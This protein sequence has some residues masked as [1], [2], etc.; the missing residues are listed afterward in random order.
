M[1]AGMLVKQPSVDHV[2]LADIDQPRAQEVAENLALEATA[3]DEVFDRVDAVVIAAATSAHAE[4]IGR[5]ATAGL[6]AFCEKPIA[7]DVVSTNDVI[8]VVDDAGTVLQVGF[9]R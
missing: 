4:L 1:H 3:I 7:V 5:A 6:P 8:R 2:I 9:Q